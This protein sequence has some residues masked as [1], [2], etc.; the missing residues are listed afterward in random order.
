MFKIKKTVLLLLVTISKPIVFAV[1]GQTERK[2]NCSETNNRS[3]TIVSLAEFNMF[4]TLCAFHVESF[5]LSCVYVVRV[6]S[7]DGQTTLT[8][9]IPDTITSWV[10]SAFAINSDVGLGVAAERAQVFI[11]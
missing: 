9:T 3:S 7:A 10:L 8:A 2:T 5:M 1:V 4:T 11:E 6:N